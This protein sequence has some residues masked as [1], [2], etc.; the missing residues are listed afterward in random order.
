MVLTGKCN[1]D[2]EKWFEKEYSSCAIYDY[3]INEDLGISMQY[4]V[5]VDFF[6]NLTN[7]SDITC[8]VCLLIMETSNGFAYTINGSISIT[9]STRQEARTEAIK[10]ANKMYN[11]FRK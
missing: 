6:D 11:V 7:M 8:R 10:K 5:Y 1:A 9:F 4:G 2:F 3:W